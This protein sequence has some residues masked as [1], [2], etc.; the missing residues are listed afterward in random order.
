[1]IFIKLGIIPLPH[2]HSINPAIIKEYQHASG[3]T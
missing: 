1:M 2:N 3:Q